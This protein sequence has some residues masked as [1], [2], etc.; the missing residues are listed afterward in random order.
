MEGAV[1]ELHKPRAGH[2]EDVQRV[3]KAVEELRVGDGVLLAARAE[4][5]D[6]QELLAVDRRV[7]LMVLEDV[8]L[9]LLEPGMV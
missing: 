9:R 5:K 3:R 7:A 1:L 4:L 6:R 8:L 2:P